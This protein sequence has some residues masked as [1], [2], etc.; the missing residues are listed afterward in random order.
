MAG[1]DKLFK[2]ALI[3]VLELV[4]S[5]CGVPYGVYHTVGKGQTLY[6]IS[7][8]Y[9]VPLEDIE[10]ANNLTNATDLKTGEKLYI[11]GASKTLYVPPTVEITNNKPSQQALQKN[12]NSQFSN[13]NNVTG[14]A[15][16]QPLSHTGAGSFVW[17]LRGK[18]LQ[19]F[20]TSNGTRHDG[21][22]I[23]GTEGAPVYAAAGGTVIYSNDT[24]KGY[25]NMII[26]K[27]KGGFVTVYAHNS[28]NIVKKGQ[29][30]QQGQVIA[31]VGHTGYATGSHLHFEIRLHAMPVNPLIYLPQLPR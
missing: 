27:H 31:R 1:K 30:V 3:L 19:G 18:L 14:H 24:I 16:S 22:D 26:I 13:S 21:I 15:N 6:N 5:A 28:V 29:A 4:I 12:N 11:P 20:K 23:K 25:G 9:N 2:I 7:R 8:V 17:P 10:R